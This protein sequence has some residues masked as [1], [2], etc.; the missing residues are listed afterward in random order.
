MDLGASHVVPVV[1]THLS[2]LEMEEMQIR[3]PGQ[4]S[5][6]EEGL[7][8]HSSTLDWRTPRDRGAWGLQSVRLQSRIQLKRLSMHKRT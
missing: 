3:S 5:P 7:A 2:M 1:K 4:E 8:N 6:L